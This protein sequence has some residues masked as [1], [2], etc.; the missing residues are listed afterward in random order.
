MKKYTKSMIYLYIKKVLLMGHM[1]CECG[2]DI[3]DG[4]G[5]IVYDI[6]SFKDLKD[7]IANDD[8]KTFDISYLLNGSDILF[9]FNAINFAKGT[10]RSY[11]NPKF[12][13][14]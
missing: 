13:F 1:G 5:H 3:W 9:L 6:F 7:Y 10:V 2:A 12:L 14:P 11:L 4:E 8:T